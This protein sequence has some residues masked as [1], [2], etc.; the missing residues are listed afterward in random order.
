MT[1]QV[2]YEC[3]DGPPFPVDWADDDLAHSSWRWDQVHNPTPLTP[4]AQDLIALKR[5][6]MYRGGEAT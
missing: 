3:P 6:G 2:I 4:L 5:Q 1:H